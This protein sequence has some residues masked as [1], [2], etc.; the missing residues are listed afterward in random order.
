MQR[1]IELCGRKVPYELERKRVKNINL[2]VKPGGQVCVS[3]SPG[4]PLYAIESFMQRKGAAIVAAI[5]RLTAAAQEVPAG[6]VRSG[7]ELERLLTEL[8][9]SAY[10]LFAPYGVAYPKIRI[11]RMKS[12]WGSCI[13]SKGTVTFNSLLAAVPRPC[14][15]YVVMHEF[16]HFL[17]ADHSP[18]FY[19]LM[20]RFM[21]DWRERRKELKQYAALAG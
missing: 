12:R 16:T 10:P 8:C 13:P 6:P 17:R 18:A 21:P 5:D 1:S 20:D 7:E 9:E 4:V 14:V 3:A 2:R 11:R 19:R 15:E